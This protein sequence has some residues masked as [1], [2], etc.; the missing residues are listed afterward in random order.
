M[1]GPE[2]ARRPRDLDGVRE[3]L[4]RAIR[5][6]RAFGDALGASPPG[7]DAAT[8]RQRAVFALLARAIADE[9]ADAL[10]ALD[11]MAGELAERVPDADGGD[12]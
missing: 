11:E 3:L 8:R 5:E 9:V 4:V 1:S 7:E 10:E 12:A 6:A 2:E